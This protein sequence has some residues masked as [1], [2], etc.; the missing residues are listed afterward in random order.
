MNI[1]LQ[2]IFSRTNAEIKMIAFMARMPVSGSTIIPSELITDIPIVAKRYDIS[3]RLKFLVLNLRIPKMANNPNARPNPISTLL[4][5]ELTKKTT[6][7]IR[8]KVK[9][10]L[11]FLVYLK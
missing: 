1:L 10:N 7:P 11:S 3:F 5:I 9:R 4:I 8:K 6:T 2:R